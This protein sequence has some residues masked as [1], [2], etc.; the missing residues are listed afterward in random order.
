MSLLVAVFDGTRE[1]AGTTAACSGRAE[2]FE[3]SWPSEHP[4][5]RQYRREAALAVCADCP[6]LPSCRQ[7]ITNEPRTRWHGWVV[8]GE[9]INH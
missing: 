2:L 1:L 4:D 5:I 9:F 8:A 3:P 7:W 6:A